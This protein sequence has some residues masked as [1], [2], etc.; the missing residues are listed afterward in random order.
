M[1]EQKERWKTKRFKAD[2]HEAYME[3]QTL[4]EVT[5]ENV[6]ELA[7]N[8]DSVLHDDFEW[9]DTIAGE[10]WRKHQ[11][12]V[13]ICNLVVEIEEAEEKEPEILRLYYTTDDTKEYKP[14]NV[15]IEKEDEYKKLLSM[16]KKEL[17]SFRKK[18]RILKELKEIFALI[19]TL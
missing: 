13:M 7:R 10:E 12:R 16:A 11:A 17:D 6:V 2:P 18:Y 14:L 9:D 5:A 3:L 8:P 19:D 1:S 4:E 15:Y